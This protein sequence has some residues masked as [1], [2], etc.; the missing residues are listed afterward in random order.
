MQKASDPSG[1]S[2]SATYAVLIACVQPDFRDGISVA[3]CSL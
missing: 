1:C 3:K 2:A